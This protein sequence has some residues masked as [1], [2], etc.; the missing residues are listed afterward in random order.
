MN[1][2]IHKLFGVC[3]VLVSMLLLSCRLH[4]QE[5]EKLPVDTINVPDD[6]PPNKAMMMSAILPGAGQIYNERY[7][8]LPILYGGLTACGYFIHFNNKRYQTFRHAYILRA[9]GD[10]TTVDEFT[11]LYTEDNLLDLKNY[12]R[13]N[14]DLTIIITVA[15]YVLNVLDAYVDAHLF[16]FNVNDNLS[17]RV[18]PDFRFDQQMR[19]YTGIQLNFALH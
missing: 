7:W 13:R 4:A 10:S 2:K 1:H 14:R 19:N 18:T 6:H 5:I 11:T 8:K 15:V 17:L 9:D 16:Y 12:Y 3:L